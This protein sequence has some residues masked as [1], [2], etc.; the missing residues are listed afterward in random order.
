MRRGACAAGLLAF[1]F[2]NANGREIGSYDS[3]PQKYL[4]LEIAAHH[5][6]GLGRVIGRVPALADRPAFV[7]DRHGIYRSAYPLPSALVAGAVAWTLSGLRLVDLDAPLAANLVA[8]TTASALTALLVA[9]AFLAARRRVRLGGAAVI[10]LALGAGTNLWGSV[11]QTLWQQETSLCA[12]MAAVL[13]LESN[14]A[15]VRRAL[16]AGTL[17]GVAGWARP[18]LAP[19]VA[20]LAASMIVRWRARGALGLVPL[21]GVMAVAIAINLSWFGSVLG[22]TPSLEAMHGALHRTSGSI[23]RTP[24][25]SA[26]GLLFSPSRGLLVFSPIVAFALAGLPSARREGWRSNLLWCGVA[27]ASEFVAYSFYSV[28]WG[29]HT[30]GPRYM[31]D[32]LPLLVPLAAAGIPPVTRRRAASVCAVA[33]LAW[34]V[35]VAALGAFVYPAD[36]WNNNPTNVDLFHGRL[37][38]W[39]DSQIVRA[40]HAGWN[41]GN[42]QLFSRAAFRRADQSA[43]LRAR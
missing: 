16:G 41:P 17:L 18:Q 28:W 24:W 9:C 37:W 25:I 10:T 23:S 14:D 7:L 33:A 36:V 29:G 27:A 42:F 43:T 6:L 35:G 21:A 22:A 39:R 15:T 5:S 30:Y 19:V 13:L 26:A 11:S 38:D 2:F 34:S 1:L 40:A 12:L 32:L 20:V 3:Q 8:K 31:L 4:A